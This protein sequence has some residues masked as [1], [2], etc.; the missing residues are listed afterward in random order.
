MLLISKYPTSNIAPSSTFLE[1]FHYYQ[2]IAR[3]FFWGLFASVSTSPTLVCFP[4][5]LSPQLIYIIEIC[6]CLREVHLKIRNHINCVMKLWMH[7]VCSWFSHETCH[8]SPFMNVLCKHLAKEV[9]SNTTIY[10]LYFL[11]IPYAQVR[12]LSR[13]H[14]AP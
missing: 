9:W 8:V 4:V 3:T 7:I 12:Y 1:P 5:F 14:S 10:L 11:G 13:N 2:V 6:I